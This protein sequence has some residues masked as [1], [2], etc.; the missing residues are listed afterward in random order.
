[1][2][3]PVRQSCFAT[4]VVRRNAKREAH[5]W[6]IELAEEKARNATVAP[7]LPTTIEDAES[8]ALPSGP[9]WAST[10]AGEQVLAGLRYAQLAQDIIVIS[11][12]TGVGKS[13]A[14]KHYRA[15]T[16]GAFYALMNPTSMGL[17][18]CLEEIAIASGI[19]DYSPS[20]GYLFRAICMHLKQKNALLIIDDAHVLG[21]RALDQIRCIHDRVGTGVALIGSARVHSQTAGAGGNVQLDRLQARIGRRIQLKL[22]SP[23]D[24]DALLRAWGYRDSTSLG[25]GRLIVR[26]PGGLQGL[27]KALRLAALYAQAEGRE[28][29]TEDLRA[30]M[31]DAGVLG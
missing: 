18:T 26:R 30:A 9:E 16:P 27:T 23:E 10:P 14:A 6:R 21:V 3:D 11:G 17:A 1:M 28:P 13:H 15:I 20:P 7:A 29:G 12:P 5:A 8:G 22:S 25:L 4:Q 2:S 19:N 24:A 31:A